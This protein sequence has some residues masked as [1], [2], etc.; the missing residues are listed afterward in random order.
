M[1]NTVLMNYF[2]VIGIS[3]LIAM[4]FSKPFKKPIYT[5]I[6]II[7]IN[8]KYTTDDYFND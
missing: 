5:Y 8:Q 3:T 4:Y 7:N 2:Y 1:A 6:Q